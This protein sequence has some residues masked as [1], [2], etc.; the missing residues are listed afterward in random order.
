MPIKYKVIRKHSRKSAYAIGRF[1]RIYNVG[2]VV[3]AEPGSLGI[4]CFNSKRASDRFIREHGV[5]NFK[6]ILVITKD[7]GRRPKII[8]SQ[9]SEGGLARFYTNPLMLYYDRE[10]IQRSPEGTICY[11]EVEVLT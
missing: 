8:G 3:V 2:D 7:K 9:Q 6:T 1:E 11:P 10:V 4:M 5:N